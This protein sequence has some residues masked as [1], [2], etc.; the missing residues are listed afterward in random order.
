MP[1]LCLMAL[2]GR[3]PVRIVCS[4]VCNHNTTQ[5]P[6]PSCNDL[7]A[8]VKVGL[9]GPHNT[10]A[11]KLLNTKPWL[12][13]VAHG[14]LYCCWTQAVLDLYR[15]RLQRETHLK[16]RECPAAMIVFSSRLK[17]HSA[18]SFIRLPPLELRALLPLLNFPSMYCDTMGSFCHCCFRSEISSSYTYTHAHPYTPKPKRPPMPA[19]VQAGPA[20]KARRPNW[21]RW[22]LHPWPSGPLAQPSS[23]PPLDPMQTLGQ[24]QHRPAH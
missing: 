17:H 8:L 13:Y 18:N 11:Q 22:A 12:L 6:S 23:L 16:K 20:S 15:C 19:Q 14:H 10:A 21:E 24:Q 4:V 5:K 3:V 7:L 9:H 2:F 1:A